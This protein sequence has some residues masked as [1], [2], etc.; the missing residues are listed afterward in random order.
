MHNNPTTQRED[1]TQTSSSD[2]VVFIGC[3]EASKLQEKVALNTQLVDA[4]TWV[5]CFRDFNVDNL[6]TWLY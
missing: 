4:H 6:F 1:P 5:Q 2:N 3:R